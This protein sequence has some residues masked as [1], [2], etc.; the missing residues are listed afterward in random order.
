MFVVDNATLRVD[1]HQIDRISNHYIVTLVHG[2]D[3]ML[4]RFGKSLTTN[5]T[6]LEPK[7]PAMWVYVVRAGDTVVVHRHYY[8]RLGC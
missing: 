5:Q 3:G 7:S 2:H 1:A 8:S 6:S 4:N